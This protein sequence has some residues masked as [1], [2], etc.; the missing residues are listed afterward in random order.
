MADEETSQSDTV[1]I[2]Y[3]G[4]D[5]IVALYSDV[6]VVAHTQ[7]TF[8][9]YFYQLLLPT[10]I[11]GKDE[12]HEKAARARCIAR[13][14]ITP[15]RL[16]SLHGAMGKNLARFRAKLEAEMQANA[17]AVPDAPGGE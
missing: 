2:E 1:D 12:A 11:A 3:I 17:E 4:S 7:D 6:A 13:I 16:L 14:V 9:L 5:D 15:Q 10:F 8:T